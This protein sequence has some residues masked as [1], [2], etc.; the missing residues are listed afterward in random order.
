MEDNGYIY[1]LLDKYKVYSTSALLS[2]VSDKELK[3]I[4]SIKNYKS[5]LAS[6]QDQYNVVSY[7]RQR[8]DRL[9]HLFNSTVSDSSD[10]A[11]IIEG[12]LRRNGIAPEIFARDV[13]DWISCNH[14]KKN[15][16]FIHGVKNSGKTLIAKLLCAPFVCHYATNQGIMNDFYYEGFLNKTIVHIEEPLFIPQIAEDMKSILSGAPISVNEKHKSAKQILQRTPVFMTSNHHKLGR[17]YL[18]VID[19]RALLARCYI[20][21]FKYEYEPTCVLN[22]NDMIHFLLRYYA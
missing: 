12:I 8:R 14:Q 2:S 9:T 15:A 21:C 4:I 10:N 16:F 18:G 13:F 6:T 19:E 7:V 11:S 20:Y 22:P 3:K 5:L 1:N 17:G